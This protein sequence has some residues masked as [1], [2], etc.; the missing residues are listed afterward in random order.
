MSTCVMSFPADAVEW[1]PVLTVGGQSCMQTAKVQLAGQTVLHVTLMWPTPEPTVAVTCST[2][3][4]HA[5][6][7]D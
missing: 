6:E 1:G 5:G 4:R 2:E 3:G 7:Q